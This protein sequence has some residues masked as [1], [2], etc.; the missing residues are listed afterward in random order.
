[1]NVTLKNRE[2][3]SSY[4]EVPRMQHLFLSKKIVI[5]NSRVTLGTIPLVGTQRFPKKS[6]FLHPDTRM[7]VCVS[8]GKKRDFFGNFCART[9]WM[10]PKQLQ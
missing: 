4:P 8:G 1:M 7:H 5:L 3:F 10:I 6:Y 2:H 9:K